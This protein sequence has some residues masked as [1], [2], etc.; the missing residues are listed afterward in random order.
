MIVIGIDCAAQPTNVGLALGVIEAGRLTIREAQAGRSADTNLHI[1]MDWLLSDPCAL[2][3]LDAPL[4]WPEAMPLALQQHQAGERIAVP[5]DTLFSRYTDRVIRRELKKTPLE[6][7]ANWIARTAYATLTLLDQ[8]RHATGKPIPLAWT[9]GDVREIA[10]IEVY[11][12]ATL[13]ALG[14]EAPGYRISAQVREQLVERLR[15]H[16]IIPDDHTAIASNPHT[17]DAI[18]CA[19]AAHDFLYRPCLSPQVE[20]E[21]IARKEGWIWVRRPG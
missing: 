15:S 6:V 11:P 13:V 10:A 18:I 17:L 4:G 9:P 14:M 12:A 21:K 7:G 1:L 20:E 3:A 16:L 8:V 19:L 2:L 5:L